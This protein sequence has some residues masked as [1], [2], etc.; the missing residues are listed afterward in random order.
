MRFP[1]IV[2]PFIETHISTH[3]DNNE[4]TKIVAVHRTTNTMNEEKEAEIVGLTYCWYEFLMY[5]RMIEVF[6]TAV[7]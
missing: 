7:Q 4:N 3:M 2:G 1:T 5:R 6:P